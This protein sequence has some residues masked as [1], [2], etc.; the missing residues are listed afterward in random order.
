VEK[1]LNHGEHR[2]SG[3]HGENQWKRER[4]LTVSVEEKICVF[5]NTKKAKGKVTTECTENLL[6]QRHR[7]TKKDFFLIHS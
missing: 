7:G 5:F 2:G 3:G 6:P 4:I 1:R